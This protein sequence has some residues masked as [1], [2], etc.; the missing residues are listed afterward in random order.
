MPKQQLLS[1]DA[2]REAVF[3][4]DQHRCVIC[5][6]P[7]VDAHHIIERRL[8]RADHE[9][10]GYFLNNGASLCEN[11]HR[12]AEMTVL[13]V[14]DIRLAAGINRPVIPDHLYAD[15]VIDKWGNGILPSG[16]R[17]KG[18]LFSDESVQKI[19]A[20]GGVLDLFRPW[21]KYPR[22]H[23][24]PWSGNLNPDDRLHPD[25]TV[26]HGKR[27]IVSEKLDGENSS[28]YRNYTHARSV[29]GRHHPSRDWLKGFWATFA[30][31][32]PEGW[33][34]CGENMFAVHSIPYDDLKSYFYGFSV[35]NDKN[36]ALSWDDTLE[37][38]A[39]L[40]I[41]P[42]PVLFDGIY[43]EEAIKA[44]WTSKDYDRSEGYVLRLADE[45]PYGDF[46]LAFAKFV[47]PNHIQ[48]VKHWMFGQAIRKNHIR[49][50]EQS[51]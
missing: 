21:T 51:T 9:F 37:W 27:V 15:A 5:G 50:T 35:W 8:F 31:D 36:V 3:A 16:E 17:T 41:T 24:L 25:I 10:G 2:F 23:H 49:R 1:R 13:T 48:T 42:V 28:L 29:D 39:L 20:K 26:F 7:A 11:H 4:R 44:L 33:R 46:R 43:D 30:S 45:I 38:F 22:T 12:A 32:I 40:D 34:I 19:L 18:E 47:R 14:E 6:E